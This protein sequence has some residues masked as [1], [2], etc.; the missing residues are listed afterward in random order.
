[1]GFRRKGVLKWRGFKRNNFRGEMILLGRV[2]DGM[3]CTR[4]EFPR[5]ERFKKEGLLRGVVLEWR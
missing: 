2:I 5:G 1:M 4:E 3:G